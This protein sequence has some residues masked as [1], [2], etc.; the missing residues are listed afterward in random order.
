MKVRVFFFGRARDLA[1][2]KIMVDIELSREVT[3]RELF[4]VLSERVNRKIKRVILNGTDLF[5][6]SVNYEHVGNFNIKLRDGD[7]I[8]IL[9]PDAGG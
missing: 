5:I 1:N 3:L 9:Q 4:E 6:V 7:T 8:A 2:G